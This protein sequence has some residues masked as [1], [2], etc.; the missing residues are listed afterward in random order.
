MEPNSSDLAVSPAGRDPRHFVAGDRAL[1]GYG[2]EG[3]PVVIENAT[4]DDQG[5]ILVSGFFGDPRPS[6]ARLESLVHRQG[7]R[8]CE[9]FNAAYD[10]Q[11]AQKEAEHRASFTPAARHL[12]D[13]L[14][15]D[16]L[17]PVSRSGL[18][19]GHGDRY[20]L[21]EDALVPAWFH[22]ALAGAALTAPEGPWP[23]WGR[24][25]HPIDWPA[26]IAAHPR[27]LVPDV[28]M[29]QC[30]FGPS[31]ES[32]AAAFAIARAADPLACMAVTFWVADDGRITVEPDAIFTSRDV[33]EHVAAQI[34]Q[35]LIAGGRAAA[36]LHDDQRDRPSAPARSGWLVFG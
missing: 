3:T 33:S 14:C 27:T 30:N 26:L 28:E 24:T 17:V 23:N 34:D 32:I 9:A 16:A 29:L 15:E 6:R 7:C 31:W 25:Q 22:D 2:S 11:Q 20:R 8:P 21:S 35:T 1:F 36:D 18:G 13:H 5:T 12:A 4:P 19:C 10:A